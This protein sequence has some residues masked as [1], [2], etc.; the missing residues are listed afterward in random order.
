MYNSEFTTNASF[1][2]K[3]Q[4]LLFSKLCRKEGGT[5]KKMGCALVIKPATGQLKEYLGVYQNKSFFKQSLDKIKCRAWR[6]RGLQRGTRSRRGQQSLVHALPHIWWGEKDCG[7]VLS[8]VTA[9]FSYLKWMVTWGKRTSVHFSASVLQNCLVFSFSSLSPAKK[10][11][12]GFSTLCD[13][14]FLVNSS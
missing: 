2:L 4:P 9:I 7:S 3:V 12:S 10:F 6:H 14:F 8:H 11:L 5:R 13:V 1:P